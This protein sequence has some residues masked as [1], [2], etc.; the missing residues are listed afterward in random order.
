MWEDLQRQIR[1]LHV[2]VRVERQNG[3][4]TEA[5]RDNV[6]SNP[7]PSTS[8]ANSPSESARN[9]KKTLLENY[10]RENSAADHDARSYDPSQPSTS[11]GIT[12]QEGNHEAT[13]SSS[14]NPRDIEE[15]TTN[16]SLSSLLPSDAELR[17]MQCLKLNEM[18]DGL[19]ARLTSRCQNCDSRVSD[20]SQATNDHTYSNLIDGDV[21]LPSMSSIV[22]NIGAS[23]SLPAVTAITTPT[24]ES[25]EPLP[26]ISSFV[27]GIDRVDSNGSIQAPDTNTDYLATG[28]STDNNNGGNDQNNISPTTTQYSMN[29]GGSS[30]SPS[31]SES[32]N[33]NSSRLRCR[34]KMYLRYLCIFLEYIIQ[35]V[36]H[37]KIVTL[38]FK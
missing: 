26:S 34:Q 33:S 15:S 19:Y 7:G 12:S 14:S 3:D 21:Q 2:T 38:M 9:F 22:S 27:S 25:S 6:T 29:Q 31:S 36:Y 32:S 10:Q 17:R 23:S 37:L 18:L 1:S 24:T 30:A 11:R 5:Q 35:C 16:M 13:T 28:V 8:A 20:A 4:Q